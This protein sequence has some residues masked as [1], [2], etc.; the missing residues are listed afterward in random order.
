MLDEGLKAQL[1][2]ITPKILLLTHDYNREVRETMQQLWSTMVPVEEESRVLEEKWPEILKECLDNFKAKE[3]RK[4]LSACLLL[5]ELVP[6]KT[7]EQ[8]EANFKDLFLGTL[9]ITDDDIDKVK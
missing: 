5:A 7:W 9:A 4:R 8:I 2:K 6:S 3:F 1:R